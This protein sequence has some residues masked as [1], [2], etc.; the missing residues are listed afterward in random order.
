M[1]IYIYNINTMNYKI[2]VRRTLCVYKYTM[3]YNLKLLCT[4]RNIMTNIIKLNYIQK[5]HMNIYI[6]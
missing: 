4:I 6:N 3:L 2:H 5:V 1:Y